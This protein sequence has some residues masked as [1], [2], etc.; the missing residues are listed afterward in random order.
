MKRL[1]E[2][3]RQ[4]SGV[5]GGGPQLELRVAARAHLE[6]RVFASI[7]Q[8]ESRDDLGVAAVEALRQAEHGGKGADGSPAPA[9]ETGVLVVTTIGRRPPVIPREEGDGVDLVGLEA[10]QVAVLDQ[11]IGVFVVTLV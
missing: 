11:V 2:Q 5:T 6:Q 4:R 1:A 7:V 3:A 9:A 10:A 8:F